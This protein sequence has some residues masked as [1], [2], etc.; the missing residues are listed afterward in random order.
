M[1]Q[2]PKD[3]FTKISNLDDRVR[4]AEDLVKLKG[5]L[6]C[7][8]QAAEDLFKLEASRIEGRTRLVC[9]HPSG[10]P[11]PGTFPVS[12]VVSFG[13]GHEKYFMTARL[14]NVGGGYFELDFANDIFHLQRRQSYRIRIPEKYG[15]TYEIVTH[16]NKPRPMTGAIFDIS[17]GGV[18]FLFPH[19]R[20]VLSV[21]DLV[22]GVLK[23]GPRERMPFKGQV[24]HVKFERDE[25]ALR[26]I[27]GIEFKGMSTGMESRLFSIVMELHRELLARWS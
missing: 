12:A 25:T 11:L 23:I 24:R 26:Q 14:E 17:T 21:D 13:V 1:E 20:P 18:R 16:D 6:L 4:L 10:S 19:N 3:I 5:E 2:D 22:D 27:V 15:G 7:K 8:V 9:I